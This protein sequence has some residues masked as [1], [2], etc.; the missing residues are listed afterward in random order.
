[1]CPCQH[2]E[3]NGRDSALHCRSTQGSRPGEATRYTTRSSHKAPA[4]ANTKCP[5]HERKAMGQQKATVIADVFP[6]FESLPIDIRVD[7]WTMALPAGRIWDVYD[8]GD[9]EKPRFHNPRPPPRIRGACREAWRV[10]E[11][12]G[13]WALDYMW[14]NKYRDVFLVPDGLDCS[15]MSLSLVEKLLPSVHTIAVDEREHSID[16][17]FTHLYGRGTVIFVFHFTCKMPIERATYRTPHFYTLREGDSIDHRYTPLNTSAERTWGGFR[18]RQERG[19]TMRAAEQGLPLSG[20]PK[21][22]GVE[23]V[24]KVSR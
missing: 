24:R 19:W 8:D 1:M 11:A 9:D 16:L 13:C 22:K 2:S 4:P 10:T 5:G 20:I 18:R 17:L 14:F 12:N 3:S 6:K 7:I 21:F 15:F 23:I